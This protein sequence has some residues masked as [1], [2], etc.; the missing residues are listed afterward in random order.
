[1]HINSVRYLK[2][3]N[4]INRIAYVCKYNAYSV[5]MHYVLACVE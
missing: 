1:M 5:G 2:I 3:L 4:R